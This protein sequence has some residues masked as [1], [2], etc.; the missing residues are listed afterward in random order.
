MEFVEQILGISYSTRKSLKMKKLL[1][2]IFL[3]ATGGSLY[4]I[5]ELLFRGYSH[6]SMFILGSICFNYAG[7]QNEY[8]SWDYPLWKQLLKVESF[9]LISEFIT[10]CIVNLWLGWNVW[11]YS[12]LTGNILGQTSWQFALLFLPL[13]L[14]AIILDDYLRYWIFKEEKPYYKLY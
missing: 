12:N 13:C 4:Y 1:K 3:F 8:T 6:W 5:V 2:Y 11:D 14:A 10:G 9:V 7:I